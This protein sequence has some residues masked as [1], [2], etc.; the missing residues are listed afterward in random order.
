MIK[1]T[2]PYSLISAIPIGSIHIGDRSPTHAPRTLKSKCSLASSIVIPS[3]ST[4]IPK[5]NGM[6]YTA[7]FG[8]PHRWPTPISAP[9]NP[10][11]RRRSSSISIG[12]KSSTFYDPK[13]LLRIY[14][15]LYIRGEGSVTKWG[16][17]SRSIALHC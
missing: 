2:P 16:V 10:S 5:A 6:E 7:R 8:C 9:S 3:R 17:G 13:F 1:M 15:P 12:T 14:T 11:A 4:R